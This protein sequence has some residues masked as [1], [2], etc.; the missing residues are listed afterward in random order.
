MGDV[1]LIL[2]ENTMNFVN[3]DMVKYVFDLKGSTVARKVKGKTKNT[4][5]LKDVNFLKAAERNKNF[6]N[7]GP[8]R[9]QI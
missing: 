6:V 5:T 9:S 3:Q 4:T 2:M 8:H 7:L 1:N